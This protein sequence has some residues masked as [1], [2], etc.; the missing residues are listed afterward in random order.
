MGEPAL[1]TVSSGESGPRVAFCHGLLGQ[2]RNWNQIAKGLSDVCRPTLVDMPDHGRSPWSERI[3]YFDAAA[4]LAETL[5]AIDPDEP[6]T[7][8]GHSMGGK[9]AMVLALTEPDLVERLAVVDISPAPTAS[10]TEFETFLA[11]MR[12]I[13]LDEVSSRADADE[14]MRDAAP[15]PTVRGFLLQNLRRDGDGWRWLPNLAVL[16]RDIA[17]VGGWPEERIAGL[18]PFDGPVLWLAG[19]N[20][21]YV[22]EENDAEMRRLFPRV[23]QVTV[24]EA[25]HW[26]HSEQPEVTIAALRALI[27]AERAPAEV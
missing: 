7:V 18:P 23:R 17:A 10:F 12:G 15:H 8:V 4:V 3:D 2:G 25:G 14:A 13:D 22:S 16:E 27:T 20:S 19:A 1:H 11:G 9:T 5:R 6:W 26:V 21:P 24:K